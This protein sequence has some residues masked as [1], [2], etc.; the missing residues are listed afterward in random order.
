MGATLEELKTHCAAHGQPDPFAPGQLRALAQQVGV[1]AALALRPDRIDPRTLSSQQLRSLSQ[2][3]RS[4]DVHDACRDALEAVQQLQLKSLREADPDR[5]Q[6]APIQPTLHSGGPTAATPEESDYFLELG[7]LKPYLLDVLDSLSGR[8]PPDAPG[9]GSE[10]EQRLRDSVARLLGEDAPRVVEPARF[11]YAERSRALRESSAAA[12]GLVAKLAGELGPQISVSSQ[13]PPGVALHEQAGALRRKI[14]RLVSADTGLGKEFR[15]LY[16]EITR[17]PK[18]TANPFVASRIRTLTAKFSEFSGAVNALAVIEQTHP[19]ILKALSVDQQL[20]LL[21]ALRAGREPPKMLPEPLNGAQ[22][23]LY[24]TMSLDSDFLAADGRVRRAVIGDL[25][26]R[27]PT[28]EWLTWAWKSWPTLP[29]TE[30]MPVLQRIVNLHCQRAGFFAPS[31]INATVLPG[32]ALACWQP[33]AR[34]IHLNT[35]SPAFDDFEA[36]AESIFHENNHNYQ[37][38]LMGRGGLR[39]IDPTGERAQLATQVRL[40]AANI[41]YYVCGSESRAAYVAQPVEAHAHLAGRRFARELCR[42][43]MRESERV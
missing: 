8:Y 35:A 32:R 2:A 9:A 24:Q 26:R 12:D 27:G 40:F 3:L 11:D 15:T 39:D 19:V 31:S 5:A 23:K 41:D 16:D 25:T 34:E 22:L 10:D 36:V 1:L 37:Y 21:T 13:S 17:L 43:L 4:L 20:Q 14:S 29:L 7:R 6:S 33:E 18:S 38:A 42:T 30:R 28:L